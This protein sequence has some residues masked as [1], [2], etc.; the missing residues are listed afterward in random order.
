MKRQV[1]PN[2]LP[3]TYSAFYVQLAKALAGEDDLPVKAE[4]ASD[5]IR[6]IELARLSSKE[7]R[8]LRVGDVYPNID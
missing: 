5:V 1:C 3:A 6:L 7:E 2:A 4:E 8:T